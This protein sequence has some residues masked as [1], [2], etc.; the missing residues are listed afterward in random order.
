MTNNI[1]CQQTCNSYSSK[2]SSLTSSAGF[3]SLSCFFFH[4][5]SLT[6]TPRNTWTTRCPLSPSWLHHI[7]STELSIVITITLPT[8]LY[9]RLFLTSDPSSCLD[10]PL[11]PSRYFVSGNFIP[12]PTFSITTYKP[13]Y[14]P[15]SL[16]FYPPFFMSCYFFRLSPCHVCLDIQFSLSVIMCPEITFPHHHPLLP[17]HIIFSGCAVPF[18]FLLHTIVLTSLLYRPVTHPPP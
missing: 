16:S 15:F 5:L 7:F 2:T 1:F 8:V 11:L 13:I 14:L 6:Y 17:S 4:N 18:V 10:N 9:T 12:T 3:S